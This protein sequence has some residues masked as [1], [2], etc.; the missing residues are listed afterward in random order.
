[1]NLNAGDTAWVLVSSSLVMLMTPAIGLFYGGMVERKNLLST[2]MLSFAALLVVTVQWVLVGYSL[3]F[4]PDIGHFIGGLQWFALSGVGQA[5]GTYASNIPHLAFMLFQMKFAIITPALITGVF[6]D[7]VRFS[8]FIVFALIW[9][10]LVYDPVAHWVW[11]EGGWLRAIGSIDFAGGTVVH[12]TSGVAALAICLA[13]RKKPRAVDGRFMPV[14]IPLTL[15]GAVLLWFGWFGFNGGSAL[16]ANGIAAQALVTTNLAAAA[17]ALTWMILSTMDGE[18]GAV[19]AATGAVVGLIA[20][21]PAC[22]FVDIPSSIIIG[23]IGAFVSYSSIKLAGKLK[24]QD[25]LDVGACHG[26]G[27]AW[28]AV[29]T[30][31]F[32][33]KSVNPA[34]VDGAIHGN[35]SLLYA[36][37]VTVAA[38]G[39]FTFVS[40]YVIAKV[41]DKIFHFTVTEEEQ[42]IGLDVFH[43][44]SDGT[45]EPA[46]PVLASH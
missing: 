16:A 33:S 29:A 44:G 1:M 21:T 7:R 27:G 9:T 13:L 24:I 12:I 25:P 10:T 46:V 15:F 36:Q 4:G 30:G 5:A 43:Y 32:A 20:I 19:G 26:M 17:A 18:P 34:G 14:S 45:H 42:Q 22:G 41:V 6:V 39:A 8:A 35:W 31:I 37:L 23:V 28:G 40:T 38:V 11:G 2:I 3:S